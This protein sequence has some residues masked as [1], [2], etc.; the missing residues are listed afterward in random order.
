MPQSTETR[1][2]NSSCRFQQ[3]LEI[4]TRF[5]DFCSWVSFEGVSQHFSRCM[6][7]N[8]LHTLIGMK[9]RIRMRSY[10]SGVEDIMSQISMLLDQS[11]PMRSSEVALSMDC[12]SG[13][14]GSSP[15]SP[16]KL[17][18]GNEK[19]ILLEELNWTLKMYSVGII[20]WGHVN[21]CTY[22]KCYISV[23]YFFL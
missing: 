17:K 1:S 7:E 9:E 18:L 14:D 12:W 3:E 5:W 23:L 6:P 22:T 16:D 21:H 8:E 10:P 11:G 13:E 15:C 20:L 19:L 2:H 4:T